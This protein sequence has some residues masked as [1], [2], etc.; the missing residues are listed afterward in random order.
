MRRHP[1]C[2][3]EAKRSGI[4]DYYIAKL[5]GMPE[6][7]VFALRKREGLFPEYLMIDTC[8][9]GPDSYIPYFYS[10]Y[11]GAGKHGVSDRKRSSFWAPAPSGS[12]RVWNLTTPPSHAG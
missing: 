11:N 2:L 5:W 9:A 6:V 8:A 1:G 7:E 3:R 12:D 10:S 4:S